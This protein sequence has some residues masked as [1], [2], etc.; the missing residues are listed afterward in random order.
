M[1]VTPL[2]VTYFSP[3]CVSSQLPP[4]NAAR[5]TITEPGRIC[6]TISAVISLGEGRPGMAAVVTMMSTLL[7]CSRYSSAARVL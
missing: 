7:A 4:P 3:G 6:S 5:S 1:I 2:S